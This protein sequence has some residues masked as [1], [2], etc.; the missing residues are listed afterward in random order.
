M[1]RC[2]DLRFSV[3]PAGR[4]TRQGKKTMCCPTCVTGNE[5]DRIEPFLKSAPARLSSP[6]RPQKPWTHLCSVGTSPDIILA[7]QGLPVTARQPAQR[8]AR[9]R[10]M[11]T[12]LKRGELCGTRTFQRQALVL[13][14][15]RSK[16]QTAVCSNSTAC[17][18]TINRSVTEALG[19]GFCSRFAMYRASRR[20][21]CPRKCS[22]G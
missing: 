4:P 10:Y 1:I 14:K 18:R 13:S 5:R 8:A 15:V 11:S 12:C 21:A 22:I 6:R 9:A 7:Q 19:N 2:Y 3:F 16:L 17:N 20:S